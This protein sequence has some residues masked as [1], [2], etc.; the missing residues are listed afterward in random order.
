MSSVL[1]AGMG[2]LGCPVAVG[3]AEGGVRRLVLA[4]PDWVE[5]SNLQR[6]ILYGP[7]DLG[8]PKVAVAERW[9]RRRFPELEVETRTE[10]FTGDTGASLLEGIDLV[11]DATDDPAARFVIND[12]ALARGIPAVLGGV[13]GFRGLCLAVAGGHGPCFRCLFEEP[14]PPEEAGR[15]GEAGVLGAMAG[16]VGHLQVVRALGLLAGEVARHTGFVTTIDGL[17]GTLREVLLPVATGC[18]A[19]GGIAARVDIRGDACPMT[20][21]RTR[22]ALERLGP[23]ETLDVVMRQGEPQHNIP[24]N[25]VDE[26][27]Q[28]LSQGVLGGNLFRVVARHGE[29]TRSSVQ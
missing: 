24:R 14:P 22:L 26:G 11:V 19:C 20:W 23:G 17:R 15:C 5:A 8:Q 6:Q 2:G 13:T 18:S 16:V 1:I 9:L 21:V 27:H 3:L 12:Q 7:A 29:R 25:L 10:R 28:L 4:D